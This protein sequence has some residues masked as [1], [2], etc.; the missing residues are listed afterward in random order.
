MAEIQLM[1]LFG[2]STIDPERGR[3]IWDY[4]QEFKRESGRVVPEFLVFLNDLQGNDFNTIFR[5]FPTDT[6]HFVHSSNSI[7]WLSQVPQG[8]DQSNKGNIYVAKSSP[9][10]VAEAYLKQFQRDFK[11]FLSCRSEEVLGGGRMVLTLLGR[12]S[13]HPYSKECCYF[14]ELLAIALN[15]M[16]SQGKIQEEKLNSFNM[17]L[18]EPSPAE[19]KYVIQNEGSFIINRLET[20]EINWDGEDAENTT[21]D[22]FTSSHKVANC[23]RAAYEPLLVCHFGEA[24]IDELFSRYR[25]IVADHAPREESKHISIVISMTKG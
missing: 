7:H 15:D 9:P 2:F 12:R 13:A 19:V 18:Y 21:I 8:I 25:E 16:A 22:K 23:V 20:F 3:K 24:I 17:P 10:T 11:V 14:F 5:L 4:M 1:Y 6:L